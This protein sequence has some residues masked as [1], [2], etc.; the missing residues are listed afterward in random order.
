MRHV[1][2]AEMLAAMKDGLRN[3]E[4]IELLSPNDLEILS[5]RRDLRAKIAELEKHQNPT[6]DGVEVH[7]MAAN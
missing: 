4:N 7:A 6:A 5:E 3:L 2:Q 1:P